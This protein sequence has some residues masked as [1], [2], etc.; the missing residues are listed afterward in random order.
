MTVEI[1][2]MLCYTYW[3][4][5]PRRFFYELIGAA[6]KIAVFDD[7]PKDRRRLLDIINAW[8]V[9]EHHQDAVIREFEDIHGMSFCLDKLKSFDV[10]FLDI[11][12]PES[13]NAGYRLAEE[14][15]T[16]NIR[17]AIIFTTNSSEYMSD[18]FEISTYRY[19]M[20]PV[21]QEKVW[22]ALD[23]LSL[24]QS[25]T[26]RYASVFRG[27]E[28]DL[29]IE[30]DQILALE[31]H[32]RFHQ[33]TITLADDS[34]VEI[35]L[36]CSLSQLMDQYLPQEFVQCCRGTVIN[37]NHVKRYNN[38]TVYLGTG[39]TV[40]AVPIGKNY[41]EKFLNKLVEYLRGI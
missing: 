16:N 34:H 9:N 10:F 3:K 11:M 15:R 30:H 6:M 2:F 37:L 8:V 26:G 4:R 29:L 19:L 21:R 22:A 39:E 35:R 25:I 36:T 17:A 23:L 5:N 13:H 32:A 12:T 27:M 7:D 1:V 33:A 40:L 41:R 31:V 24:S 14:I 20:K 28:D 38:D 18:A